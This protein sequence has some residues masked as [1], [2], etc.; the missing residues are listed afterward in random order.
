MKHTKE[1]QAEIISAMHTLK[2]Y[3]F[4]VENIWHVFD[5]KHLVEGEEISDEDAYEIL[6]KAIGS[7]HTFE[8]IWGQIGDQ[9]IIKEHNQTHHDN[10]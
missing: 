4:Y 9:L 2:F 1:Q 6:D 7:E 5:V 3:G 10:I 8:T